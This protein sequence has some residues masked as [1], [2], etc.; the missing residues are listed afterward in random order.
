MT[1]RE[2]EIIGLVARGY[3]TVEIAEA[4]AISPR[5]VTAHLTRL[6]AKF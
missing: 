4:L 2:A 6:M 1:A 5:A 3:R